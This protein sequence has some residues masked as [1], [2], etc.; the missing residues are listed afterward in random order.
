MDFPKWAPKELCEYYNQFNDQEPDGKRKKELLERLLTDETMISVWEAVKKALETLP[1]LDTASLYIFKIFIWPSYS[2][3]IEEHL[4]LKELIEKFEEIAESAKKLARM[5]LN[6]YIDMGH[7]QYPV[8]D[9]FSRL[10]AN[11]CPPSDPRYQ[12]I[13]DLVKST[14]LDSKD[15]KGLLGTLSDWNLF[16]RLLASYCPPSDPRHQQILDLV[17]SATLDSK[18]CME[19]LM[20]FD[21][22]AYSRYLARYCPPSDPRHQQS[23]D[24]LKSINHYMLAEHPYIYVRD[25]HLFSKPYYEILETLQSKAEKRVKFLKGDLNEDDF[26]EWDDPDKFQCEDAHDTLSNLISIVPVVA[27]PNAQKAQV[28]Y[29]IRSIAPTFQKLFGGPRSNLLALLTSVVFND[30]SITESTVRTNMEQ[31]K[32]SLQRQFGE[33][34]AERLLPRRQLNANMKA[35]NDHHYSL[36]LQMI[37]FDIKY[38]IDQLF[39][40]IYI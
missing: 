27:A 22:N 16:F 6:K 29:F 24:Q 8:W 36:K 19:L 35:L 21:M 15:S 39:Y 12:Q 5:T 2:K 1:S 20:T 9:K 25:I 34:I 4:T 30:H 23:L 40:A 11:Y 13:L 28:N 33:K 17:I 14:A 37:F 3:A 31:Y 7:Y 10:L 38:K 18:D 26:D 32:K